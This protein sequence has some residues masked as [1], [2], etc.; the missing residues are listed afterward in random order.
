MENRFKFR[1]QRKTDKTLVYGQLRYAIGKDVGRVFIFNESGLYEIIE[2]TESQCTG[3]VI[4]KDGVP[5]DVYCGD[6]VSDNDAHYIVEW[7]NDSFVW[8][9][10]SIGEMPDYPAWELWQ[11]FTEDSGENDIIGNIYENA[12]L[13]K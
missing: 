7:D 10:K 12:G 13:I 5:I 1:G 9:L 2:G 11:I 8:A 4:I 6:I 3:A